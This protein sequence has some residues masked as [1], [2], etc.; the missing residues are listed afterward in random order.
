MFEGE[1]PEFPDSI[2]DN[3]EDRCYPD[4]SDIQVFRYR[5]DPPAYAIKAR[6]KGILELIKELRSP[7]AAN[8]IY[9]V[10][11]SGV[12]EILKTRN[13]PPRFKNYTVERFGLKISTSTSQAN[14]GKLKP[15]I[16]DSAV[17]VSQPLYWHE[18]PN[19]LIQVWRTRIFA[20][21]ITHLHPSVSEPL[22][23][24]RPFKMYFEERW[25]PTRGKERYLHWVEH[26]H[27]NNSKIEQFRRDA[28]RIIEGVPRRGRP[29][30]TKRYNNREDFIREYRL[31]YL[32]A[33]QE[34]EGSPSQELVAYK[35][36][37]SKSTLQRRLSEFNIHSR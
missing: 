10:K 20:C 17:F 24:P 4:V 8:R 27:R 34:S 23:L 15:L 7:N 35:M 28:L 22:S 31:A 13:L 33:A 21:P 25:H 14:V 11:I 6:F 5:D 29:I 16:Q 32:A 2:N 1:F 30:G 9:C 3:F 18:R 36:H 12:E 19:F 26:H 37:I